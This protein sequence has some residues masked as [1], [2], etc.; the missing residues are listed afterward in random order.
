MSRLSEY[1]LLTRTQKLDKQMDEVDRE[2]AMRRRM[3][4]Q[5][6]VK[7]TMRQEQADYQLKLLEE[8][9]ETVRQARVD[10]MMRG[11]NGQR[12]DDPVP[13]PAPKHRPVDR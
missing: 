11:I 4:P 12:I 9:K 10:S 1:S 13:N 6:V 7:G 8:V 5:W 3:Y 2:L